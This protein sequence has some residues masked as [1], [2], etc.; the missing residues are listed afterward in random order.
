MLRAAFSQRLD[1]SDGTGFSFDSYDRDATVVDVF[2]EP[3]EFTDAEELLF[4]LGF[5]GPNYGFE[6]IPDRFL[7]PSLARG[8]DVT[9]FLH[10][11]SSEHRE[12]TVLPPSRRTSGIFTA[13]Q[14]S[15]NSSFEQLQLREQQPI[16]HHHEEE[17]EEQQST[18]VMD[19]HLEEI[20]EINELSPLSSEPQSTT[21]SRKSSLHR[22]DC[23]EDQQSLS[24][25]VQNEEFVLETVIPQE[26]VQKDVEAVVNILQLA[27]EAYR[28]QIESIDHCSDLNEIKDQLQQELSRTDQL[29]N[30]LQD[31]VASSDPTSLRTILDDV[32][33]LKNLTKSKL[34]LTIYLF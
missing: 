27:V 15:E 24:D 22:Q 29:L 13:S 30:G 12:T 3:E 33:P 10:A 11:F 20:A 28:V 4:E 8:I 31:R 32:I 17:E 2:D 21:S 7:T 25:E 9:S 6:R 34:L 14:P 23:F 16:V 19:H 26:P 1:K 18:V 5:G